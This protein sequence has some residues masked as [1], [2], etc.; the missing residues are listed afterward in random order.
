MLL[1]KV[2]A[3]MPELRWPAQFA[4]QG[5]LEG[6]RHR[7]LAPEGYLLDGRLAADLQRSGRE[8][9][10]V[11]PEPHELQP[12]GLLE[13]VAAGSPAATV[14]IQPAAGLDLDGP[15]PTLAATEVVLS[16][17]SGDGGLGV[18]AATALAAAGHLD[19]PLGGESVARLVAVTGGRA[20]VVDSVLRAACLDGG[21][22]LGERIARSACLADLVAT[23]TLW[24]LRDADR[25]RL[26]ALALAA[27][28]GYAH[29]RLPA[30]RPALR[31]PDREPWWQPLTGGWYRVLPLWST[32]ICALRRARPRS[33]RQR[34]ARLVGELES[35]HAVEEAIGLC[36]RVGDR[37]LVARLLAETGGAGRGEPGA[38]TADGRGSSEDGWEAWHR[39]RSAL[40][41]GRLSEALEHGRRAR[42]LAAEPGGA[43]E[44]I[45][46]ERIRKVLRL[47]YGAM[48]ARTSH[49]RIRLLLR[50]VEAM[51]LPPASDASPTPCAGLREDTP[52]ASR[53]APHAAPPPAGRADTGRADTGRA[54]T[55]RADTGRADTGRADTGRVDVG[56]VDVEAW[57]LGEF[58]LRIAG[59]P[60]T[61]WSG[62][63]G[64]S[65][66]MLLLLRH[67]RPIHRDVMIDSIWP[68]V[69]DSAARN[70]LNAALHTLRVDLRKA[71]PDRRIVV[72]A[73]ESYSLAPDLTVWLDTEEFA[74]GCA[75]ITGPAPDADLGQAIRR[76]EETLALYAGELLEDAPYLDWVV[77]ERERLNSAYL[78]LLEG[79]AVLYLASGAHA[80]CV[81]TCRQVI[82]RDSCRERTHRL[83]MRSYARQN[84]P[85]KA[86]A[87]YEACCRELD[88]LLGMTPGPET[89]ALY[90]SI[91]RHLA[92]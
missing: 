59:R 34:L 86:V 64:R 43:Y 24:A 32:A 85:H 30:L 40:V 13:L 88:A 14:V 37:E 55:G 82:V 27:R 70:R 1:A 92:V 67:P 62:N 78:D 61:E 31:D 75:T 26:E 74:R 77:P 89:T 56:R 49:G 15:A 51:G 72:H 35:D 79:L 25:A 17:G 52:P 65:V 42:R 29:D 63:L 46:S 76:H 80:R 45:R 68:G 18:D 19:C 57:L 69:P 81:D 3:P 36:R 58:R 28:L 47:T 21:D 41:A 71:V 7:L 44:R 60:V 84:Q 83:L 12:P 5:L 39:T 38:A 91:R 53:A 10:W 8:L 20:A 33:L 73:R 48:W 54:D 50:A 23:V 4:C 87:Q 6:S 11:R 16:P 66:L 22:R 90:E 2:A 9:G